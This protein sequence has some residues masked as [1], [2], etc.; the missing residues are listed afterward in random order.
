MIADKESHHLDVEQ[1]LGVAQQ[2]GVGSLV[3][4]WAV[5]ILGVLGYREP[6][7]E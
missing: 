2:L 6:V 1:H 4:L 5:H 3:L 7:V